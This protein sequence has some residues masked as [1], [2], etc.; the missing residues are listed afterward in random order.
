MNA[1][2][3]LVKLAKKGNKEAFVD[4]ID[5]NRETLYNI[6]LRITKNQ[7]DAL[8]VLSET[9]LICW[10]KLPNLKSEKYFKTWITRI[11]IN[12]C[13]NILRQ[14]SHYVS[15]MENEPAKEYDNDTKIV[16]DDIMSSLK[17]DDKLVLS[18]FYFDDY[19]VNQIS[20]ILE[21]SPSAVKMRLKRS[22]EHFKD[23]YT[24][25]HKEVAYEK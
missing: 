5:M 19:S 17:K 24:D 11:L 12:N 21:I 20:E 16:V 1:I 4:L 25:K 10:E 3:D 13:Y 6:A 8:D 9:V 18:M 7:Q 2:K 22:R 15:G 23:I 14:N